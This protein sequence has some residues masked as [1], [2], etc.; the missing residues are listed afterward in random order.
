M[1]ASSLTK[2]NDNNMEKR[3]ERARQANESTANE[4]LVMLEQVK[5][6]LDE[7]TTRLEVQSNTTMRLAERM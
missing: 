2:L 4:Q 1:D 6:T 7:H 3:L 5:G